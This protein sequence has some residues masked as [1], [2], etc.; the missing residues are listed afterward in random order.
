[1]YRPNRTITLSAWKKGLQSFRQLVP[2]C[3]WDILY[4]SLYGRQKP[5][6][7]G[8]RR[9]R[10]RGRRRDGSH[11]RGMAWSMQQGAPFFLVPACARGDAARMNRA[12]SGWAPAAAAA[13]C[14]QCGGSSRATAS[15][16]RAP[17][18]ASESAP[19]PGVAAWGCCC[20]PAAAAHTPFAFALV[21]RISWIFRFSC[22]C[23][24]LATHFST[25]KKLQTD[26]H[27]ATSFFSGSHYWGEL[28]NPVSHTLLLFFYSWRV[29]LVHVCVC[30]RARTDGFA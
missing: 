8:C 16:T 11:R 7:A 17:A 4:L 20:W 5:N 9:G 27:C 1:M 22:A 15:Q 18:E 2:D 3:R 10:S 21:T 26:S 14:S 12:A 25:T 30:A 28:V 6:P 13:G 24:R 19:P 29:A 23:L